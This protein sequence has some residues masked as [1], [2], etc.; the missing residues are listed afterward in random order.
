LY[1]EYLWGYV[2]AIHRA[3]LTSVERRECYGHLTRW[4]ASRA[5]KPRIPASI[6]VA[7]GVPIGLDVESVVAGYDSQTVTQRA[8]MQSGTRTGPMNDRRG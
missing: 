6:D 8:M 5:T 1:G 7:A 2:T 3:P 4:L